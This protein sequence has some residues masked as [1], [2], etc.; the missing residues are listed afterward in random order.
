MLGFDGTQAGRVLA[1]VFDAVADKGYAATT[2]ADVVA[3]AAVSKR[4]FYQHHDDK[5][6]CFAAACGAAA[7]DLARTLRAAVA[8]IAPHD[9][10]ARV[11]TA[12]QVLLDALATHPTAAWCLFVEAPSAGAATT[13]GL[14][15]AHESAAGSLA[16]LHERARLRH[17]GMRRPSPDAFGLHVG[18]AVELVRRTLLRAGAPALPG[19]LPSVVEN[20]LVLFEPAPAVRRTA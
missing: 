2:V 15:A 3:G 19:L 10:H 5:E 9:W 8:P 1:A 12:W 20:A 11:H 18:G 17:P 14:L 13:A 7:T 6:G 16:R 4:T